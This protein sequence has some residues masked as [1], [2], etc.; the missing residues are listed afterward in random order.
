MKKILLRI[1]LYFLK[2]DEFESLKLRVF[3]KRKYDIEVGL[4]SYGCFDSYRISPGT[5]IGRYCSFAP[6]C[7]IFGRNHGIS[8][9]L[10]HPY[11][12]NSSLGAI[13]EDTIPYKGCV[14]EDDVWIGH[15]AVVL[16]SV[17]KI[18]RGAIIG[19]GS[20]LTMDVP[21]YSIAVGNPARIIKSRFSINEIENLEK[22]RYWE[23]SKPELI[24]LITRD[25]VQLYDFSTYINNVKF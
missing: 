4:Y 11:L 22:I 7:Y 14:I 18:G 24:E 10:T 19:A 21:A 13:A 16:P 2:K 5:K 25:P 23:L 1:Y 8:Y 17:N 12:Y 3:F 20:V 15:N 9:T 6:T